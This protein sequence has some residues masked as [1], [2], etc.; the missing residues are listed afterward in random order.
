MSVSSFFEKAFIES[1]YCMYTLIGF[2]FIYT[3]FIIIWY[4]FFLQ[5]IAKKPRLNFLG[6]SAMAMLSTFSSLFLFYFLILEVFCQ[7]HSYYSPSTSL[8]N[9]QR[10]NSSTNGQLSNIHEFTQNS[11]HTTES[12]IKAYNPTPVGPKYPDA[13]K[14]DESTSMSGEFYNSNVIIN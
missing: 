2:N 9:I 12:S 10:L 14:S 5:N 3:V 1:E 4:L 7:N 8:S 11:R 13:Y 6:Q